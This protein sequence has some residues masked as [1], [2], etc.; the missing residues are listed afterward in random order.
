MIS[1]SKKQFRPRIIFPS[2]VLLLAFTL[3]GCDLENDTSSATSPDQQT[4]DGT[5]NQPSNTND[6]TSGTD[7][8]AQGDTDNLPPNA[9]ITAPKT[10]TSGQ[11]VTLN[12]S[13]SSD[14]DNDNLSYKWSQTEGPDITFSDSTSSSLIFIAP[15]VAQPTQF[16]FQLTVNDGN[17]A[18]AKSV[19]VQI[20]PVADNTG[21]SII[22]RSPQANQSEVSTT[23]A[24]S[25]SFDEALLESS[26]DT[27]S[28]SVNENGSPVSGVVSYDSAN[29]TITF[30]PGSALTPDTTYTVILASTLEDLA[31]NAFE[32]E[33]WSFTTASNPVPNPSTG[34]DQDT[35]AF[36]GAEGFG[37]STSGGRGGE[38][39]H[40]TN[41]NDS[42][43]GSFRD[44]V[45]QP[46]RIVV[47]DVGGVINITDRIVIHRNIYVA[48][49][50]APGGGITIYGNGI[51]LN[52]DSG[53]DIIRYIRIR[54]GK[55][56]DSGKDALG[57]SGGQNYMFDHV[58]ISWGRDGT[59]DVNGTGIDNLSFQESIVSQGINNANHSTGGLMQSGKWSMIRSLYIDNKTRNPKARG[60]HEFINNVLYNWASNGYIMGDTSG[61]SECNL[62]GNYFIYG[63]SSS[64]NSHITR[65]TPTFYVYPEDNWVDSD[66]NG[67]L[68]GS[69]LT[70]YKTATVMDSPFDYPG[71]NNKLSAQ[72][73]LKHVINNVGASLVR[74]AV[75][76]LLIKQ[77][78]SYG[79]DGQIINTEVDN[80]ISANVGAVANGIPPKDSDRDGMPDEWE[81]ARGLNPSS[82]DDTGDDDGDGYTNIEEY[83]SCIV[84]EGD[85]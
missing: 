82:A 84:G 45:S 78:L 59:L 30:N 53:N 47:F 29:N 42:G 57:I 40:V 46:N 10:I 21:P 81:A 6:D 70:D 79:A 76:E 15:S 3:S 73:A 71:V 68:D 26:V 83:L 85:C 36:P 34:A 11:T 41:L 32:G 7:T 24:I 54:M 33:S 35:L 12:G 61:I 64:S 43:P 77:L 38:V 2:L 49:Q 16:S 58:S 31:G 65:T 80:G 13:A 60:T 1:R 22:S 55:N 23:A 63:P 28:F 52:G 67:T 5:G 37:R 19:S 48:G 50:T 75:D 74:D 51:A 25:V 62:I 72:D 18:S 17:L 27:E 4:Q 9:I 69:L 8:P 39:Y 20:L 66:T 56:G 14:P 44:A